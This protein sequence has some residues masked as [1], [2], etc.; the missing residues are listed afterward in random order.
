MR[1]EVMQ[2]LMG[3]I[4][5]IGFS[6]IFNVRGKK[7]V[8]TTIGAALS[9]AVYLAAF[10]VYRDRVIG[11]FFATITVGALAEILARIIKTPVIVLLVPMLIPLFPGSDLFYTTRY[12][13]QGDAD[14]FGFYLNLVIREAGAM[15]FGII[16]VTSIVQVIMKVYKYVLRIR[17]TSRAKRDNG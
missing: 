12:L 2:T 11:F 7:M 16:L 9:W 5:T 13:V 14:T 17:K 8:V 1:E 15:A 3:M 4:G 10:A 6:V